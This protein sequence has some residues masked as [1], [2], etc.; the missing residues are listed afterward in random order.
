MYDFQFHHYD[1][2]VT[3]LLYVS[4]LNASSN[5]TDRMVSLHAGGSPQV[6]SMFIDIWKPTH[7]LL[8]TIVKHSAVDVKMQPSLCG[9]AW[10]DSSSVEVKG[11]RR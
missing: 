10:G 1:M 8:G 7:K 6:Q 4:E 2:T 3:R 9:V 5:S 11:P